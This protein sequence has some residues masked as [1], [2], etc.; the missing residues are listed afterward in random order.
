[1]NRV[2]VTPAAGLAC[3]ALVLLTFLA[4]GAQAR[5]LKPV[6]VVKGLTQPWALAFL[7]DGRML[8][9]E[10]AGRIRVADTQGRLS[11]PLQASPAMPAV[12]HNGQCGLLDIVLDPKF[13]E[14][15]LLYWTF[16]EPGAGG[17]STAVARARLEGDPGQERLVDVRV[18]FSQQPKVDSGLHCGSRIAFDRQDHLWV[19]LG[20]RFSAKDSAQVPD[21][22][23]GKVV[24]L[25]RDGAVPPD[26]P[27]ANRPGAQALVWS[28]GH[29]NIQGMATH[30]VT[31]ELW[32]TEHGPQG[33]DE[34]NLVEGGRNYGWPVVT[35]G[36][37]YGTGTRIGEEGP[38]P[39]IEMPLRHWVPV[40]VAPSGLA[41]VTSDRYPGWKGSLVMG[42]L[43]AQVL[44]R[45][46]LDGR[47]VTDEQRLLGDFNRRIRDVRQGPD[48]WLYILTDGNDAQ[49]L[50]LEN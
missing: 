37:N 12:S 43:R 16:A 15:R 39:G 47:R 50:R 38:R 2:P 34:L 44:I 21:N 46:S 26:N 18:I 42:T 41:F 4:S 22:H 7:P 9:T 30:P 1:M 23:I 27:F 40:S 32:A 35:Y 24:R 36:R 10:K 17:N 29:R 28:L 31:G 3:L 45:L 25:T 13:A 6:M 5:D 19:G 48:G 20:D 33:G 11:A 8:V 49:V 14:N